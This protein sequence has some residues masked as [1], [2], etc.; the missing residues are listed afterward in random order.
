M[1]CKSIQTR[2]F[3]KGKKL[4]LGTCGLNSTALCIAS[5]AAISAGLN[6]LFAAISGE[7]LGKNNEEIVL[8]RML[9]HQFMQAD[10]HI[11]ELTYPALV[12]YLDLE[13]GQGGGEGERERSTLVTFFVPL[14][15][16]A[17]PFS[18]TK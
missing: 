13:N 10:G 4:T 12:A 17:L 14:P 9:I 18:K 1:A 3:L 5:T 16:K 7:N 11:L 2:T 6:P 15:D 8:R